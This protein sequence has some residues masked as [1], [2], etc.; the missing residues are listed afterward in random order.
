MQGSPQKK[1][2]R[3]LLDLVPHR[4]P[5]LL[6]QGIL[7]V[8]EEGC[9]SQALVDPCAWYAQEDGS[10]PGWFGIELMAQTSAAYSWSRKQEL[11][12]PPGIGYLLGTQCYQSRLA[13]FPAGAVLEVEAQLCFL[14]ES[15][16]SAFTCEIR[17]LGQRVA[18][19]TLKTFEPQ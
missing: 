10:M 16:L 12:L 11:G 3:E 9:I 4:P 7:A 17:H 13:A 19:A 18:H 2:K 5:M 8:T 1:T 15:G 14:D 6:L